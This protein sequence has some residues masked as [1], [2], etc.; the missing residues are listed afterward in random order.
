MDDSQKKTATGFA[1]DVISFANTEEPWGEFHA[2][3]DLRVYGAPEESQGSGGDLKTSPRP[4]EEIQRLWS[5]I[6]LDNLAPAWSGY[7]ARS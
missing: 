6:G 1:R 3:E 5:D 2:S 7:S 4:S